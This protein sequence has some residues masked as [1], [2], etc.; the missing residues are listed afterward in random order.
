MMDTQ[1]R[2]VERRVY[3]QVLPSCE[4]CGQM[5]AHVA[6]RTGRFLYMRCPDCLHTWSIKKDALAAWSWTHYTGNP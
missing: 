6:T 1:D 4:K 3:R 2:P 5:H